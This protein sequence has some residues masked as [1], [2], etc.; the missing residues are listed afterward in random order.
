[1]FLTVPVPIVKKKR[2]FLE[3]PPKISLNFHFQ[4]FIWGKALYCTLKWYRYSTIVVRYHTV[5]LPYHI[6]YYP[7]I[8]VP[9]SHAEL[10]T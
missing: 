8:L 9:T 6:N 10:W 4:G 5:L 7:L 3:I 2:N 1:M